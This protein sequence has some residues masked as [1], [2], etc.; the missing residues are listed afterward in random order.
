MYLSIVWF[1]EISSRLREP[2]KVGEMN[3]T[4]LSNF[5]V[6]KTIFEILYLH[7]YLLNAPLTRRREESNGPKN[8]YPKK[9]GFIFS[10]S[11]LLHS[12]AGSSGEISR[13]RLCHS[14]INKI[15]KEEKYFSHW[16]FRISLIKS[17]FIYKLFISQIILLCVIPKRYFFP[18]SF[19]RIITRK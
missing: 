5:S 12:S 3:K 13:L 7:G 10:D 16:F 1:L 15:E 4:L 9:M 11:S 8:Q 18:V 17:P 6:I 2:K 14:P 19:L